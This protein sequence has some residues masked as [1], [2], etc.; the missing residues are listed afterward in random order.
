MNP[1]SVKEKTIKDDLCIGCG[2]CKTVCPV[3]A[4]EMKK[5]EE[6]YLRPVINKEKCIECGICTKFCPNTF[7]NLKKESKKVALYEDFNEFG[8]KNARILF[9][10]CKR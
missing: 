6:N 4:I 2:I 10:I 7:E 9:S 1:K 3:N 8:I 5:C